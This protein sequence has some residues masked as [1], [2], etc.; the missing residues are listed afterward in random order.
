MGAML[1]IGATGAFGI[2]SAWRM[3]LKVR[4]LR[5]LITAIE[6]M[7]NE[8]CDR[9]TPL[10]ELM[11]R[12]AAE[13]EAPVHRL[14]R[15]VTLGMA[16]LGSRSFYSIWREAVAESSQLELSESERHTLLDLGK[17]LGRYDAENQSH[18]LRY[19]ARRL[20]GYLGRAEARRQEQGKVHAVLG[21]AVGIFVALILM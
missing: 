7:R 21:L 3:G 10:P 11:A 1:V 19:T 8:I 18:V 13:T 14:F 9:Q 17:V 20:E 4:V 12:L 15:R 6:T 2:S 16:Q 5:G